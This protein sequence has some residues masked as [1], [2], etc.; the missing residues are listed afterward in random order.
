MRQ[1]LSDESII[2]LYW[3]RNEQAIAETD[4]KYGPYCYRVAHNILTSIEDSE[5]C[6]NDTW[7]HTWNAIPP[8]RPGVLRAFLAKITRNLSLDRY[9]RLFS[10]KRGSGETPLALEEL[11]ESIPGNSSVEAEISGHELEEAVNRFIQSLPKRDG[12]IFLRRY[13][14]VDPVSVI[15]GQV[16]ISER[17]CLVILSRT[18][19][20]L[21]DYL[22]KE[23]FTV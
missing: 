11:E 8:E 3:N 2:T 13:F 4:K 21:K 9:R 5:E 18:R 23:G 6:V 17:N 7:L 19:K 16:G 10:A 22:E 12:D 14:F 15:A 1:T 20:K